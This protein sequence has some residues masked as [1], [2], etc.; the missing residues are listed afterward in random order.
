M[1]GI[2]LSIRNAQ[3]VQNQA[4]K[5]LIT[6]VLAEACGSRISLELAPKSKGDARNPSDGLH[7][8]LGALARAVFK[9]LRP[10]DFVLRVHFQLFA[11]SGFP[12]T[13]VGLPEYMRG[14]QAPAQF[15]LIHEAH[16]HDSAHFEARYQEYEKSTLDAASRLRTA[17]PRPRQWRWSIH[18]R[19]I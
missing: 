3:S 7:G 9:S 18:L 19:R 1:E 4:R 12:V 13:Q 8:K 14:L 15:G 5:L 17:H 16:P 6:K 10:T 11:I 2:G